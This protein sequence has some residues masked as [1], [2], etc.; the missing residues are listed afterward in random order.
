MRSRNWK[1]YL[2]VVLLVLL[3]SLMVGNTVF[4]SKKVTVYFSSE[5]QILEERIYLGKIARIEGD[6]ALVE[7]LKIVDLG[8]SPLPGGSF[9]L[10]RELILSVLSYQG[11]NLE[12]MDLQGLDSKGVVVIRESQLVNQE[13][14]KQQVYN[15]IY[16]QFTEYT[17][18]LEI[19][20]RRDIPEIKLPIGDYQIEVGSAYSSRLVGNITVPV[21]IIV[22]G[23]DYTR[24]PVSLEVKLFTEV[25]VADKTITRLN[26]I[27][28]DMVQRRWMEVTQLNGDLVLSSEEVIGKQANRTIRE[29]TIL[30]KEYLTEPI[31]IKRNDQITIQVKY[32][33]VLIQASAKA[34]D[35]GAKGEWIWVENLNSGQK[36]QAQ[37]IDVGLAQ[38]MVN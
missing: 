14:V 30:I 28:P 37:V 35:S 26:V 29:D 3:T 12:E 33:G 24:I 7:Q 5:V 2:I 22:G 19:N 23:E 38:I 36:V 16:D 8:P 13:L 10:A 6:K 31:L 21:T 4:A 27:S 34:L 17:G 15:Y 1:N 20:L 11:Y 9:S 32:R 25:F 18:D